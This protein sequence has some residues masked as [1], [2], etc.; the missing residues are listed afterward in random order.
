MIKRI[1]KNGHLKV[2]FL[3][4]MYIYSSVHIIERSKEMT[5][6]IGTPSQ[7]TFKNK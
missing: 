5:C 7:I 4:Y 2:R 1:K 3:P 6:M